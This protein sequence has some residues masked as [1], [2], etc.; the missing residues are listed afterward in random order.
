M[1]DQQPAVVALLQWA[2]FVP[3]QVS[4]VGHHFR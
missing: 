4:A 1:D 2:V 3:R